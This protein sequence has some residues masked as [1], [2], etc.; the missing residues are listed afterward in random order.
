MTG[1]TWPL[2]S[3]AGAVGLGEV[4]VAESSGLD[5]AEMFGSSEKVKPCVLD[6]R[7]RAAAAAW[8]GDRWLAGS[9]APNPRG[10]L[11][12]V[13]MLPGKLLDTLPRLMPLAADAKAASP[14]LSQDD[15][16][17]RKPPLWVAG[18]EGLGAAGAVCSRAGMGRSGAV[19]A[20]AA[21]P[22]AAGI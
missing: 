20:G 10:P 4:M 9:N 13:P 7:S 2:S 18:D 16:L 19:F 22:V 12:D 6:M 17:E 8:S 15:R 11:G 14:L 1:E 5:A 21:A 3:A